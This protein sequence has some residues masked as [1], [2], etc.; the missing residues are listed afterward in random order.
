MKKIIT[1]QLRHLK[2]NVHFSFAQFVKGAIAK[3]PVISTGFPKAV[4]AFEAA[5]AK[6]DEVHLKHNRSFLTPEISAADTLRD[7]QFRRLRSFLKTYIPVATDGAKKTAAEFLLRVVEDYGGG[8]IPRMQ[9]D[10]ES[11][12]L[13]NLY[14]DLLQKYQAKVTLLEMTAM[15]NEAKEA[16]DAFIQALND[17]TL[18]YAGFTKGEMLAARTETDRAYRLLADS[19]NISA[20]LDGDGSYLPFINYL[21]AEIER[22]RIQTGQGPASPDETGPGIDEGGDDT[23]TDTPT[24]PPAGGNPDD[25]GDSS[26]SK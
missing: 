6:E 22:L 18:S 2:N 11:G 17:R 26:L 13:T 15:V 23:N 19:V 12:A 8:R 4:A 1:L 21:N 14:D 10:E 24:T 20:T 7:D 16:N 5:Y 3:Y 9:Y 25:G